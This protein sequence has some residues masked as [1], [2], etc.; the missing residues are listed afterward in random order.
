MKGFNLFM[1][2][3]TLFITILG[4]VATGLVLYQ[5]PQLWWVTTLYIVGAGLCVAS[6]AFGILGVIPKETDRT[7]LSA[8]AM[9][10]FVGL[11]FLSACMTFAKI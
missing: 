6:G 11:M 10:G 7:W 5:H 3:F 4:S 9:I 1:V 2:G 8:Q